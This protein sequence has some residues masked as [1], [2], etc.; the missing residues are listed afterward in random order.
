M[1]EATRHHC[2]HRNT[3]STCTAQPTRALSL[4]SE[5]VSSL[6]PSTGPY[7][8]LSLE[9]ALTTHT[10][11]SR[12]GVLALKSPSQLENTGDEMHKS[13]HPTSSPGD[14]QTCTRTPGLG[15]GLASFICKGQ[16]ERPLRRCGPSGLSSAT[17]VW[18]QPG[19]VWK[20][21][22]VAVSP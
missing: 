7:T 8:E 11:I 22:N 2:S 6:V 12:G 13:A 21:M 9:A 16:M 4:T 19:T 1:R 10:R 18:K 17:T 3:I 5:N 14:F 20:E 15:P